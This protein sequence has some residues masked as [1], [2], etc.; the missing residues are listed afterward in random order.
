MAS[1]EWMLGVEI[2][3]FDNPYNAEMRDNQYCCCDIPN[4]CRSDITA[5]KHFANWRCTSSCKTYF[6]LS[7]QDCSSKQCTI[8]Q[9]FN[10]I[11]GLSLVIF[12][13][14]FGQEIQVRTVLYQ[15]LIKP[16]KLC[17]TIT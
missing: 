9:T 1:S 6:V 14:S 13:I 10:D 3:E 4:T 15:F 2:K 7:L 8:N 5:L 16:I 17:I 11:P 12:Q